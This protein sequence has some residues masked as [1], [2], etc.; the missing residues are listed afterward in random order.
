MK[1]GSE[2]EAL[3]ATMRK[4]NEGKIRN[5]KM[6]H[7][8]ITVRKGNFKREMAAAK[9]SLWAHHNFFFTHFFSFISLA[10][11]VAAALFLLQRVYPFLP[12]M[13][14]ATISAVS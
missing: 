13:L 5:R 14:A 9:I 10:V 12:L 4:A 2:W 8:Q 6:N 7:R 3:L 1:G 11:T